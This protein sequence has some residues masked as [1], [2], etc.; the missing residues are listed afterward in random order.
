MKKT[1]QRHGF[2]LLEM[3]VVV[4]IVIVLSCVAIVGVSAAKARTEQK[5][6]DSYAEIIYTAAQSRLTEMRLGGRAEHYLPTADNGIRTV[7]SVPSDA[8]GKETRDEFTGGHVCYLILDQS[9]LTGSDPLAF[10]LMPDDYSD[11]LWDGSWLVEYDYASGAVYSVF[12]SEN[13]DLVNHYNQSAFDTWRLSLSDRMESGVGYYGGGA[14]LMHVETGVLLKPSVSI[15]NAETL[16]ATFTCPLPKN[17]KGETVTREE[18]TNFHFSYTV[19]E[20]DENSKRTDVSYTST[21]AADKITYDVKEK[22]YTYTLIL[23][24]PFA[25]EGAAKHF[26]QLSNKLA[27]G[28]NMKLELTA[29]AMMDGKKVSNATDTARFN[30]LFGQGST[31]HKAEIINYRHLQNLSQ[32]YSEVSDDITKAE[33]RKPLDLKDIPFQPITNKVLEKFEGNRQP[34]SNLTVSAENAGLF[35]TANDILF[36]DVLLV[37]PHVTATKNA[38]ALV[39]ELTG[40]AKFENCGAYLKEALPEAD[41]NGNL[42][43]LAIDAKAAGGGL[44]GAIDKNCTVTLSN[45]YAALTVSSVKALDGGSVGGLVGKIENGATVTAERSYAD[46]YLYGKHTGGLVGV[47]D[48]T[49]NVKYSYAAGYLFGTEDA[50]GIALGSAKAESSYTVCEFM[51]ES[52]HYATLTGGSALYLF[53]RNSGTETPVGT[54]L[55]NIDQLTTAFDKNGETEQDANVYNL[56][57]QFSELPEYYEYVGIAS[58]PHYGDWGACGAELTV[59]TLVR[60]EEKL[61]LVIDLSSKSTSA[62]KIPLKYTIYEVLASWD[63]SKNTWNRTGN[64]VTISTEVTLEG[65]KGTYIAALD[66]LTAPET[67][68]ANLQLKSIAHIAQDGEDPEAKVFAAFSPGCRCDVEVELGNGFVASSDSVLAKS[69]FNSLFA[70]STGSTTAHIAYGRHLQNLDLATSGVASRFNAAEFDSDVN[71]GEGSP[72]QEA[73]TLT[74]TDESGSEITVPKLFTPIT[75]ENLTSVK[76]KNHTVFNLSV[77]SVSKDTDE[78][79]SMLRRLFDG[80]VNWLEGGLR[81]ASLKYSGLVGSRVSGS[82]FGLFASFGKK[83]AAGVRT[84]ENLTLDTPIIYSDSDETGTQANVGSFA[85]VLYGEVK[86]TNCYAV[87]A[88]VATT[89]G[90]A[91]GLVGFVSG[92]ATFDTCGVYIE[93][94]GDVTVQDGHTNGPRIIGGTTIGGLVGCTTVGTT[95]INKC[96][97][98]TVVGDSKN[99]YAIN[100]AKRLDNDYY[101]AGGLVGCANSPE[102]EGT[103]IT[104]S[105]A[106]CYVS[107]KYAGGIIGYVP[108]GMRSSID[109]CYAAGYLYGNSHECGFFYSALVSNHSKCSNSYTITKFCGVGTDHAT[110]Y[111]LFA[112]GDLKNLYYLY[113]TS[114]DLTGQVHKISSKLRDASALAAKLGGTAFVSTHK[115]TPYNL[116]DQRLKVDTYPLPTLDGV[117]H[118]GDWDSFK[119]VSENT[120]FAYYEAYSDGTFGLWYPSGKSTLKSLSVGDSVKVIGDGYAVVFDEMDAEGYAKVSGTA[121]IDQIG[122]TSET[123][124]GSVFTLEDGTVICALPAAWMNPKLEKGSDLNP[125]SNIKITYGGDIEHPDETY[126]YIPYY[127]QQITSSSATKLPSDKPIPIRSPRQLLALSCLYS[128]YKV[129]VLGGDSVADSSFEQQCDLHYTDYDWATYIGT[130]D[131]GKQMPIG[132][133]S[134]VFRSSYNG[135]YYFI[136]NPIFTARQN[137][138]LLGGSDNISNIGLFGYVD[139]HVSLEN[140]CLMSDQLSAEDATMKDAALAGTLAAVI[141]D[142]TVR[143]CAVVNYNIEYTEGSDGN[144]ATDTA[145]IGGLIGQTATKEAKILNSYT[146]NVNIS[147]TV[148]DPSKTAATAR[149]TSISGRRSYVVGGF[150]GKFIH[151]SKS[152]ATL[153]NC[154]SV[155][156]LT[157]NVNAATGVLKFAGF[158]GDVS[159]SDAITAGI[160]KNISVSNCMCATTGL[161]TKLHAFT[162]AEGSGDAKYVNTNTCRYLYG[163]IGGKSYTGAQGKYERAQALKSASEVRTFFN[164]TFKDRFLPSSLGI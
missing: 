152:D 15:E 104:N 45:S 126:Y 131:Y 81:G 83:D 106:D 140:I 10:E 17:D 96:F 62:G 120:G 4:A 28:V 114:T 108:M 149:G 98:A 26:Y 132:S 47:T 117:P 40:N 77:G 102:S 42:D 144:K 107:G 66:D 97:A 94:T 82:N 35:A 64:S 145:Y 14:I 113:G 148:K 39:G 123:P 33:L 63:G 68:F 103:F 73:Y 90:H 110:A 20:V 51:Q 78:Q 31:A 111:G 153:T 22:C 88:I 11:P 119:M 24:D 21:V 87:D 52:K 127:A 44:V 3:L 129:S 27:P 100:A 158:A 7:T 29:I 18:L 60:N 161:G 74:V 141:S 135:N 105:Y 46:S 146:D 54:E 154:F 137:K 19:Y 134:S 156:S 12:Y 162:Y 99:T 75:N 32:S 59:N 16:S 50:A 2:T 121:S 109:N 70:D 65:G 34:L 163:T 142:V 43:D 91:G 37:D 155:G 53:Y 1:T 9:D 84:I 159:E 76:G 36:S 58:L 67:Q 69:N 95:T 13:A 41:E 6:L 93:N 116:M 143:N 151:Q 72:W 80:V 147:V 130:A 30:G 124:V 23:D 136:K 86:V 122:P 160:E 48:G 25:L 157:T 139:G 118:Y 150:I 164:N 92:D 138:N 85:G 57:S 8:D 55:A 79:S 101:F 89:D 38:G 71:F 125:Y 112:Y 133:S 128:N 61:E 49:L 115:G 5:R 56:L